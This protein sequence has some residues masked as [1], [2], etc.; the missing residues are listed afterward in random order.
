MTQNIDTFREF[1]RTVAKKLVSDIKQLNDEYK[2]FERVGEGVNSNFAIVFTEDS[3]CG[4]SV[5][6]VNIGNNK[7]LIIT[8]NG[9]KHLY[10]PFD[11]IDNINIHMVYMMLFLV[12]YLDVKNYGA[13][14]CNNTKYPYSYTITDIVADSEW[15]NKII[16]NNNNVCKLLTLYHIG[17]SGWLHNLDGENY[18]ECNTLDL[19]NKLRILN[20]QQSESYRIMSRKVG[21]MVYEGL[22]KLNDEYKL[23]NQFCFGI[24]ETYIVAHKTSL[25]T[26]GV[27][28]EIKRENKIVFMQIVGKNYKTINIPFTSIE[29]VNI[30]EIYTLLC[31][32]NNYEVKEYSYKPNKIISTI[33][34]EEF[35]TLSALN[36][37]D[38]CWL[39]YFK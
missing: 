32:I 11:K 16:I 33:S 29:N 23:F 30:R 35:N 36:G 6:L 28:F 17:G 18:V 20:T 3:N 1:K 22:Q 24:S 9:E 31:T 10:L 13:K 27:T 37:V 26:N 19:L 8:G 12:D 14:C 4:K 34:I 7:N 25:W 21:N 2:I 39:K 15:H 38:N 5:E